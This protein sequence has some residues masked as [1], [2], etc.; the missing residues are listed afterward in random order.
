VGY[1]AGWF[2]WLS[3]V[4]VMAAEIAAASMFLQYWFAGVPLWVLAL[5]L[6]LA[7]T[8]LNLMQVSVYGE[9]EYWLSAIKVSVLILFIL[10]GGFL[11]FTGFNGHS[12]VGFGNLTAHGGFL[13]HGISG[14]AASMLV[15]MF[16]FGGTEMI[17]MTLGET[18]DPQRVIP[19]AARGVIFRILIFYVLP[20]LVIVSLIPWNQAGGN[21]SPFVTVFRTV[22]IPYVGGF[23]NF[24]MVTAVL[25]AANTGMYAASRM[26]YTQALDGQAPEFF[27]KLSRRKVPVRALLVSTSFLYVGV[28]VAFFAK[29]KTFDYLMVIPGY[30]VLTIWILIALAHVRSGYNREL[31]D[32]Y[33]VKGYSYTSWFA[34]F[35]LIVIMAGIVA[36]TPV[37]GTI[38]ALSAVAVIA[39]GYLMKWKKLQTAVR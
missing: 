33:S 14:I 1:F 7:I 16:S 10:F 29:G 20:I 19:R 22:G 39:I 8:L 38:A 5:I 12:A 36:T 4:L 26:L 23:M 11:L 34:L 35:A 25:S 18:K 6:S 24:V 31:K 15:V 9:T 13:P 32:G 2:Y 28:I 37:A 17:G 27:A 30:A 3:W 21:E